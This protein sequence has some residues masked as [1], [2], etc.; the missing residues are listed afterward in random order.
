MITY[1][2]NCEI[3]VCRR[4][5]DGVT[6]SEC[7]RCGFLAPTVQTKVE[8]LYAFLSSDRY[9]GNETI[10]TF[11]DAEGP[12][13]AITTDPARVRALIPFAIRSTRS[14]TRVKL[15][16]FSKRRELEVFNQ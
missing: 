10:M 1:C 14:G 6:V 15:V 12:S 13:L 5:K 3:A 9:C 11:Q 4:T 2:P 7:S 16:Q 8:S